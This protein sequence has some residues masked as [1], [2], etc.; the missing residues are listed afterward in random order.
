MVRLNVRKWILSTSTTGYYLFIVPTQILVS[1]LQYFPLHDYYNSIFLSGLTY[2][3][4]CPA[5]CLKQLKLLSS[6][7]SFY[8]TSCKLQD[9]YPNWLQ[10]IC[11]VTNR[12]TSESLIFC[13]LL[14]NL[15]LL[16]ILLFTNIH[17]QSSGTE[18][19]FKL[20]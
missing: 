19:W 3:I 5:F 16:Q 7:S 15:K 1:S 2:T 8:V 6:T 20:K 11:T 10:N 12:E 14:L 18:P 13:F 9:S 4:W 17:T